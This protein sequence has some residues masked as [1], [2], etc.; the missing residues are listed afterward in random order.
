MLIQ[1]S[2]LLRLPP[3]VAYIV[4]VGA[5]LLG[6][7]ILGLILHRIFHRVAKHVKGAW[8]ELTIQ[9]LEYLILPLIVIGALDAAVEIVNLP[10]RFE[11][12]AH[13]LAPAVILVIV[14]HF[15]SR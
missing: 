8:G 9:V 12:F 15:L 13:K 1:I 4:T 5:L 3:L 2:R 14:F 7:L 10:P 6:A 11:R